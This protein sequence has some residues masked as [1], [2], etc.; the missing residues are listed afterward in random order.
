MTKPLMK[1]SKWNSL[2]SRLGAKKMKV[3]EQIRIVSIIVI[4]LR[5]LYLKRSRKV[6]FLLEDLED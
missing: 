6:K 1:I 5:D 4:D 2:S 3:I